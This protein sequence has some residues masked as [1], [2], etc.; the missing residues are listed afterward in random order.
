VLRVLAVDL[1]ATSARVASV[2]LDATPPSLQVVHRHAHRPLH[3]ADGTMRWDWDRLMSEIVRGLELGCQMGP[4]ASVGV[5]TWGVDYG[6]L[7]RA[8]ALVGAPF[9]Y[10]DRRTA[11]WHD[12]VDRLGAGRLY[13]RSGIQLMAINTIFQLAVHDRRELAAADRLVMLPELVVHALT[14]LALGERTSAATTALVDVRSGEWCWDL[15]EAIGVDPRLL[16]PILAAPAPAGHWR[17]IPVHLVGGHD[18]ASAV[19]AMPG[20]PCSQAAF[21]SSG[22]WLLVGTERSH[23]DTR[24]QAREANFSNEA[25]ALGGVRFLKNVVGFWLLEQCCRVWGNPPVD[26]LVAAAARLPWGGPVVDVADARFAAATDMP[27]EI[28]SAA[29]L[30]ASAGPAEITR[31]I[32]ESLAIATAHVVEELNGL[33]EQPV[34]SLHIL[35]G[36]TGNYLL[37]QLLE[38]RC[39]L[40]V[41]SGPAEAAAL[42]NALVQ[43]IALGRFDGLDQARRCLATD[44]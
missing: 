1:G 29:G 21:V 4:V 33:L 35:G 30:R 13:A 14:G 39:Q 40:P 7:D 24:P 31:C 15:I 43:G 16:P 42:G 10:R 20:R 26:D 37:K 9:S 19:V 3:L 8:G 11:G 18:T 36:A 12:V 25:G 34:D 17:G 32:L 27:A 44:G 28:R 23:P 2:D 5:D 41:R 38:E 22:T 6:L